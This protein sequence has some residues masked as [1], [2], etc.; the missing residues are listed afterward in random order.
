MELLID[1]FSYSVGAISNE[2]DLYLDDVAFTIRAEYIGTGTEGEPVTTQQRGRVEG[3]QIFSLP[4]GN[5]LI[6]VKAS[7]STP[8]AYTEIDVDGNIAQPP[9]CDLSITATATNETQQGANDG[10]ITALSVST[11]GGIEYSLNNVDWQ[12]TGLFKNL[13]PGNYIVY[14]K[15][16]NGCTQNT[17]VT[18]DS[19]LN[20][21]IGDPSYSGSTGNVSRWVAA[22]NPI[23]FKYQRKDFK[24]VSITQFSP[25]VLK[26]VF[27]AQV[28]GFEFNKIKKEGVYIKTAKY[29]LNA[30][31][32]PVNYERAAGSSIFSPMYN[33]IL[34]SAVFNGNDAGG[35]MNAHGMKENYRIVTSVTIGD[36]PFNRKTIDA[37]HSPGVDGVTKANIQSLI[38]NI[39]SPESKFNYDLINFKEPNLAASFTIGYKEVWET[40]Q[41]KY[42]TTKYPFYV[43]YAAMQ[44]QEKG[45]GNLFEYVPFL[46]APSNQ[47]AKFLTRFINPP[48]YLGLP[49]SI[50]FLYSENVIGKALVLEQIALNSAG[51]EIGAV[52]NSSLLNSD[53]GFIM[54]NNTDKLLIQTLPLIDIDNVN[55][56]EALGYNHISITGSLNEAVRKLKV[57]LF[58]LNSSGVK[59]YITQQLTI[60]IERP[61]NDPFIYLRWVNHVGGFDY[62]RFGHNQF[63]V[64]DTKNEVSVTRL[65]EN[66]GTDE[67]ALDVIRKYSGNKITIGAD[68]LDENQIQGLEWL[69]KSIK[70]QMLSNADPVRWKTVILNTGS[71]DLKQTKGNK[72]SIKLT[73][74][75]PED[76]IQAQ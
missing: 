30:V 68:A 23:V 58:Y 14:T 1:G 36:S 50:Q 37:V 33:Y 7:L 76:N 49:F 59:V 51:E 48:F 73:I 60:N 71:F 52:A 64:N 21:L 15:D 69:K 61:C 46:S 35:F 8:Y 32:L 65:I 42:Y 11:F 26:V 13:P 17:S 41:S 29:E 22:F 74:S 43:V 63:I 2:Y 47:K 56:L 62:F 54:A 44:L 70:V 66:W 19:Y 27:S 5:D 20:P 38:K 12:G 75:L 9:S 31:P 45:A 39:V 18:V 6:I 40:G 24:V 4:K 67:T 28:T 3:Q 34:I 57:R 53:A 16:S 72:G 10:T 25:N 55:I